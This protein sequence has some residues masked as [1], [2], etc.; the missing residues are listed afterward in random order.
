MKKQHAIHTNNH[1]GRN[2]QDKG[3]FIWPC[4]FTEISP[5]YNQYGP[6]GKP[7]VYDSIPE[8]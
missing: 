8:A 5:N 4:N 7:R 2:M 3:M 1:I 6:H